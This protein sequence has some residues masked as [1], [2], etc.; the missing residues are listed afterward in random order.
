MCISYLGIQLVILLRVRGELIL[1]IHNILTGSP[2]KLYTL[3]SS[4]N[5]LD[6]NF[7]S[8]YTYPSLT[9]SLASKLRRWIFSTQTLA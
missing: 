8:I 5:S 6:K 9:H 2:L 7:N 1:L 3:Y 4:V